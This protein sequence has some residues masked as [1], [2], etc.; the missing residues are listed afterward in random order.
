M[1]DRRCLRLAP[2]RLR[3]ATAPGH[4]QIAEAGCGVIVYMRQEGRGI[5]LASKIKA[6]KFQEHG[7]DTVEANLK[8]GYDMDLREYGLG[9]Q[10][11]ADLGLKT[12]R[13]LT[14]NPRK[15]VGLEGYGLEIV[16]QVPIRIK[17]NPYNA[18]YLR[19]KRDKLGTAVMTSLIAMPLADCSP[20]QVLSG[21]GRLV[22]DCRLALQRPLR[23]RHGPRRQGRTQTRRRQADPGPPRARGIRNPDRC[24]APGPGAPCR[25]PPGTPGSSRIAPDLPPSAI[26]CLGV[27]L[28]GQTVHAAHIGEAV[29]HALM[30]IQL[31]RLVPVIHEVLLLENEGQARARCLSKTHNRG[32][33]AAQTALAMARLMGKLS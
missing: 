1:P 31:Q 27:I 11:L 32:A 16:E 20:T 26:I 15:V 23:Q 19:T 3:A 4:A 33:E 12:I 6:Y 22:R 30:Q 8:L 28:R 24:R 29:S 7:Y 2:L 5:G 17:P 18:R 9:A 13:L 14:N 10:I 25:G 21:P